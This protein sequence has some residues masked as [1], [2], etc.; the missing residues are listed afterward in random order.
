M[1]SIN[2]QPLDVLRIM[3]AAAQQGLAFDNRKHHVATFFF[4][5][6]TEMD[7]ATAG[8]DSIL[9]CQNA[10]KMC[11]ILGQTLGQSSYKKEQ[12]L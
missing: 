2:Q 4:P 7:Q 1:P 8:T 3:S 11:H 6:N 5:K 10:S 12:H 9:H